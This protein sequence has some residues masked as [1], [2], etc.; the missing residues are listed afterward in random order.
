MSLH[1]SFA[2]AKWKKR[3]DII[4]GVCAWDVRTEITIG[5]KILRILKYFRRVGNC[6]VIKESRGDLQEMHVMIFC[7]HVKSSRAIALDICIS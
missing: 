2:G 5:P 6:R 3:I 1:R 4:L 7:H